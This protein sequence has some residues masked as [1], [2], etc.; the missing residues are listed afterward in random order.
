MGRTYSGQRNYTRRIKKKLPEN[1]R[2][3]EAG[4]L[5]YTASSAN[6]EWSWKHGQSRTLLICSKKWLSIWTVNTVHIAS[7][8]PFG[9]IGGKWGDLWCKTQRTCKFSGL[10]TGQSCP[11]VQNICSQQTL[12]RVQCLTPLLPSQLVCAG[13]VIFF[14]VQFPLPV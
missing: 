11:G 1:P 3:S 5:H 12:P 6:R 4:E 7:S 13:D 10:T 14:C 2:G 8:G 9:G